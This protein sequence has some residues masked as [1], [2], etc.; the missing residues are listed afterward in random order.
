MPAGIMDSILEHKKGHSWKN[1]W[2]L[3]IVYN[4]VKSI[5]SI[6]TFCFDT[7]TKVMQHANIRAGELGYGI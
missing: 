1:W 5:V 6:L 3:N 4:L 7:W 2:Y